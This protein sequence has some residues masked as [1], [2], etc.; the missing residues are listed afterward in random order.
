MPALTTAPLSSAH[1]DDY[2]PR[3]RPLDSRHEH[4]I[5]CSSEQWRRFTKKDMRDCR[6]AG[7]KSDGGQF[8]VCAITKS[9]TIRLSCIIYNIGLNAM[10][11]VD[12]MHKRCSVLKA[13]REANGSCI[14][15]KHDETQVLM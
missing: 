7:S 14:C 11:F 1:L 10:P 3:R 6:K 15:Q 4:H 12:Q 8:E 2:W 13:G 9:Y 5:T